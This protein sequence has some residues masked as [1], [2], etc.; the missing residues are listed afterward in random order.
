MR[1]CAKPEGFVFTVPVR[2]MSCIFV[3]LFNE[4]RLHS[5]R[6]REGYELHPLKMRIFNIDDI[7]YRPREGYELHQYR[8]G[9][10][11]ES[12]PLSSP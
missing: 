10:L 12:I 3:G 5:Y 2:G 6:P 9:Q 7:R 4:E 8:G 11:V 1:L